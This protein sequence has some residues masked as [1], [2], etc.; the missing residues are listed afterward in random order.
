[1]AKSS[2]LN[3]DEDVTAATYA[4]AVAGHSACRHAACAPHTFCIVAELEELR[5]NYQKV[6]HQF[7]IK[8][9]PRAHVEAWSILLD[10]AHAQAVF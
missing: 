2:S 9:R 10:A 8:V 3:L 7:Q 5:A 4:A 1:M 6:T